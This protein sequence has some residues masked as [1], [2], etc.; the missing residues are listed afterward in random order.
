MNIKLGIYEIFSRIIPGGLYIV[1][2]A[3]F[4]II[5]GVINL[6]LQSLN[7]LP[8]AITVGLIVVSYILGGAFDNLA[9][10]LFSLVRKTDISAGSLDAFKKKHQDRWHIDFE[11]QD[12]SILLAFIR[13]KSLDLASEIDRHNAISVMLRNFGVGLLVIAANFLIAF[14]ISQNPVNLYICITMVGVSILIVREALKFRRWFFNGIYETVLAYR[15]DLEK[16]IRPVNHSITRNKNK[17]QNE[18]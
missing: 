12:W 7:N 16:S 17:K 4:L 3:Q 10:S 13:T 1:A 2:V 8:A 11:D 14:F 5:V 9:I 6:D 15:I 18:K